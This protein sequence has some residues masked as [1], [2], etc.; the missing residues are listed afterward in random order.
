MYFGPPDVPSTAHCA[1]NPGGSG[2][3]PEAGGSCA[4]S[5]RGTSITG[6]ARFGASGQL[7]LCLRL[8]VCFF[9]FKSANRRARPPW[10]RLSKVVANYRRLFPG[11][12]IDSAPQP[13][14][15]RGEAMPVWTS[16]PFPCVC[17]ADSCI[18]AGP[19]SYGT[20]TTLTSQGAGSVTD[21]MTAW[22]LDV[23]LNTRCR[24]RSAMSP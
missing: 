19:Y 10:Q 3:H 14:I 8:P 22:L 11:T 4:T 7:L 16:P 12:T 24:F 2:S 13:S 21:V 9:N 17:V 23:P 1:A 20:D 6:E 15:L 5:R 18:R